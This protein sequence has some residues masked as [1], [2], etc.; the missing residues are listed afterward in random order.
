[1]VVTTRSSGVND[2]SDVSPIVNESLHESPLIEKENATPAKKRSSSIDIEALRDILSI[3]K[4]NYQQ[5]PCQT[6]ERSLCLDLSNQLAALR[7]DEWRQAPGLVLS[8]ETASV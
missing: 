1:M 8:H 6:S 2:A 4:P 5:P 3:I 7:Y